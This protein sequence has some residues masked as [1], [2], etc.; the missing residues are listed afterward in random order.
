MIGQLKNLQ[1]KI[2]KMH[3]LVIVLIFLSNYN[4]FSQDQ[5][6][7]I[8]L[9]GEVV[10]EKYKTEYSRLHRSERM[11]L[12]DNSNILIDKYSKVI[13]YNSNSYVELGDSLEI[14]CG[15]S[16]MKK[17]L[18][19]NKSGSLSKSFIEYLN[20]AYLDIEA[21]KSSYGVP[22]GGVSRGGTV[23]DQNL[24]YSPSD[25][26]IILSD[27]LML[28]YGVKDTKLISNIVVTNISTSE[29]IYNDKPV[30]NYIN[31]NSL[32]PGKY[33]WSYKVESNGEI[34]TFENTFIIPEILQKRIKLKEIDAFKIKLND[35]VTFQNSFSDETKDFL[36]SDFLEKNKYYFSV[37][38]L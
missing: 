30:N 16:R 6:S 26:S 32:N 5:I 9:K 4:V 19:N 10:V 8:V 35:C 2:K 23:Y 31:L 15:Y 25:E 28:S 13:L 22:L 11:Y 37:K 34:I 18:A 1:Q 17:I 3:K 21:S 20:K 7:I 14:K 38:E 36:I 33:I 12:T 29:V 27:T 24:F